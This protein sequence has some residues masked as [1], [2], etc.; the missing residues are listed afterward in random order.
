MVRYVGAFRRLLP[1]V[2]PTSRVADHA[3]DLTVRYSLSHWDSMLLGACKDAGLTTLYR[4][5][6][7]APTSYDRIQLI[8]PFA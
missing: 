4:E 6:M 8:N 7:G 3:L 2:V 1:L 5:D